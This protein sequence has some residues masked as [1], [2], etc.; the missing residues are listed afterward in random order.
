MS[1]TEKAERALTGLYVWIFGY[2]T[3]KIKEEQN[4]KFP[5]SFKGALN[6]VAYYLE[7]LCQSWPL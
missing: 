6:P 3:E 4:G 7:S 5:D 2:V 1:A